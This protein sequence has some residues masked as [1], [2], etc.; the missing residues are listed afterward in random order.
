MNESTLLIILTGIAVTITAVTSIRY[1]INCRRADRKIP[2]L[3]TRE[4]KRGRDIRQQLAKDHIRISGVPF[5]HIMSE[6]TDRGVC[7]RRQTFEPV[8]DEKIAVFWYRLPLTEA[9][10]EIERN[11]TDANKRQTAQTAA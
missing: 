2:H 3:L 6:L 9:E 7:L 11:E 5:Y 8:G 4:W 1:E 10:K